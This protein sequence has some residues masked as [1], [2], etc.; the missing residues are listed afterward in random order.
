MKLITTVIFVI[1]LQQYSLANLVPKE[2]RRRADIADHRVHTDEHIELGTPKQL[3]REGENENDFWLDIAKTFVDAQLTKRVN[4]NRAKNVIFFLADGMSVATYNAARVAKGGE[5]ESLSFENFPHM[6]MVRTYCVDYQVADSACTSTAYLT[7]VKAN[8][9]TVGVSAK[10][11]RY[12]CTAQLD[13]STH[14]ESI[15]KW[16]LDSNKSA[17]IVTTDVVTG[18]SPSGAYA[19]SA[20]R[21]WENDVDVLADGCDP[22]IIDDISKQLIRGDVGSRLHVILGGGRAEM[23]NTTFIDEEGSAGYRTDGLDLIQEY[24]D[25]KSHLRSRYVWNATDF[26]SINPNEVDYLLGLFESS[27]MEYNRDV[28]ESGNEDK[29]PTLAEMT[30]KAIDILSKNENG[31]VLFVEGQKIDSAHHSNYARL[32]L[33]ETLEFAKAVELARNKVNEEDTLIVVTSDHSHTLSYNGY[34]GRGTDIYSPAERSNIDGKPYMKLMYA[35][36]PGYPNHMSAAQRTR[37]DLSKIDTSSNRFRFPAGL[38]VSSETHAGEDVAVFA[39]GPWSH[40][41]SGVY[42]QHVLTH[43]MAYASCL[44]DGLTHCT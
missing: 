12:D 36:G 14:T 42:E 2:I 11:P 20:N 33:D 3:K 43:L 24:Q 21:Y 34:G 9:G 19:H 6:G 30:E 10:V 7:G 27:T 26:R 1:L 44:G 15:F 17:G 29:E 16:A 5:E 39:S 22:N 41:F 13:P 23:R 40:L 18:A 28:V 38:L 4:T 25:A 8:Y 31:Y 37:I 32:S 35:N